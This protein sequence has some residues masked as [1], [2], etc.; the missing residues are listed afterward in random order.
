[1]R[2]FFELPEYFRTPNYD[3]RWDL[4]NPLYASKCSLVNLVERIVHRVSIVAWLL[5]LAEMRS[6][7]YFLWRLRIKLVGHALLNMNHIDNRV[8]V[9]PQR[10]KC[11]S[12]ARLSECKSVILAT[13]S[14]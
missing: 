7:K 13:V 8:P 3:G 12:P 9:V 6:A 11:G 1:M 10:R 2:A 5:M 14:S 4:K